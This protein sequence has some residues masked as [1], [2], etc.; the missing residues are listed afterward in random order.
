MLTSPSS[1]RALPHGT[2][3][4][5]A[6]MPEISPDKGMNFCC[7]T[8]PFTVCAE[9]K[10]FAVLCQLAPRT[11]PLMAFLFVGLQFCIQT[12]FPPNLA[13]TQLSFA[14]TFAFMV[15]CTKDFH[16]ISSCPCRAYTTV[17]IG[18]RY[19]STMRR[20]VQGIASRLLIAAFGALCMI[21]GGPISMIAL[22]FEK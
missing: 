7:T 11:R 4:N 12:S 15:L 19:A 21:V 1:P 20:N 9:P 16:L 17:S 14:S 22:Y 3:P 13:V 2:L 5:R 6:H 8:G 10:G 18:R